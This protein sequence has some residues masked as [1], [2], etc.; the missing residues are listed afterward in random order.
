M[1]SASSWFYCKN[2]PLI[3]DVYTRYLH[4]CVLF[5]CILLTFCEYFYRLL[6]PIFCFVY[7]LMTLLYGS[8]FNWN[9]FVSQQGELQF[10]CPVE[11]QRTTGRRKKGRI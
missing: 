8:N 11:K 1:I 2:W 5:G 9:F 3:I 6:H 10:G 7:V 4:H